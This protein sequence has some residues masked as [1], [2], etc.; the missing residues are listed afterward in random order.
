MRNPFLNFCLLGFIFDV[1]KVDPAPDLELHRRSEVA[2]EDSGMP[3]PVS[4]ATSELR[5]HGFTNCN[6]QTGAHQNG[7]KR[8]IFCHCFK[9]LTI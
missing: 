4:E 8:E 6:L 5:K 7:G 1:S 3:E 9:F 2:S